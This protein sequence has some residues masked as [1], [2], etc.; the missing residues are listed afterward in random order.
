M[1]ES[2][3]AR[4]ARLRTARA[5]KV[6]TKE[7]QAEGE[8]NVTTPLAKEAANVHY[9]FGGPP[10]ALAVMVFLPLVIYG[11]YVSCGP[12]GCIAVKLEAPFVVVP[13]M[14]EQMSSM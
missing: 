11:L 8:E 1:E 12:H 6:E 13:T 7:S 14:P 10:G 5:K 9:E 4:R 2:P 3:R